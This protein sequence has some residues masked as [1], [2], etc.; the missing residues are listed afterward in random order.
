MEEFKA[1]IKKL[2]EG[3][4]QNANKA[5]DDAQVNQHKAQGAFEILNQLGAAI[6]QYDE[7]PEETEPLD[8]PK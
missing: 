6:D 5:F 7:K 8:P 4:L 1:Y 3:G 2:I